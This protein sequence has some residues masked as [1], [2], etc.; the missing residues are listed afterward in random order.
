MKSPSFN[1]FSLFLKRRNPSVVKTGASTMFE[2]RILS[3][4]PSTTTALLSLINALIVEITSRREKEI[5]QR[6]DRLEDIWSE[7]DI[8][9]KI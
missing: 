8:Y 1:F 6:F 2:S 9:A 7:Y 3:Y 5:R 4:L